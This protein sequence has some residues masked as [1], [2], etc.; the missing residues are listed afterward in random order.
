MN[1]LT[2]KLQAQASV[3][4]GAYQM[5]MG[6]LLWTK[7][8]GYRVSHKA[9]GRFNKEQ[10]RRVKNIGKFIADYLGQEFTVP[11]VADCTCDADSLMAAWQIVYGLMQESQDGWKELS[12]LSQGESETDV[13]AYADDWMTDNI[14]AM[15]QLRRL[16]QM[17]KTAGTD[18]AA[19][20][21][22]DKQFKRFM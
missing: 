13:D 20:F 2:A 15:K 4:A 18:V 19:V 7:T 3:E 5:S 1:E 11:G 14:D 22:W 17:G 8:H 10:R 16:M 9:L 12:A 6:L 21:A